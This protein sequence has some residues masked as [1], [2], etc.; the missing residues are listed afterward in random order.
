MVAALVGLAVLSAAGLAPVLV[1]VGRRWIAV[2][3]VPL[4]G[5]AVASSA[6]AAYVA[7]GVSFLAWFVVLAFAVAAAS[8]GWWALDPG[9][10]RPEGGP[11]GADRRVVV[12]GAVGAAAI[13]VACA[14]SLRGL[15]TPTVGFDARA[16]WVMRPGWFLQSQIGR[17]SC[18]ERV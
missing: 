9:R 7:F 10:S 11:G 8:L 16:L 15:R 3:L 17:A 5:A 13:A 18:R 4:A 6:A 1:A 2:P 14:A 12:A